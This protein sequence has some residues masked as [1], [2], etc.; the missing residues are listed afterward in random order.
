MTAE[1][2][3]VIGRTVPRNNCFR[4]LFI[5]ISPLHVS[6]LTGHPREEYTIFLGSYLTHTGSVVARDGLLIT[7]I[8]YAQ[9][10]AEPQN[11]QEQM[12]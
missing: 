5:L 4:C 8:K 9:Q 7:L 10:D 6:A 1:Q 3:Q 2:V 12:E 11:K